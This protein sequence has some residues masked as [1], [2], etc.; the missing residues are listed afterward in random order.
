[1][2]TTLNI[3]DDVLSAA[4][5]IAAQERKT[6]GKVISELARQT[7]QSSISFERTR[8]GVVLLPA[9]S[10]A[11][12]VA[13]EDVNNVRDELDEREV[14]LANAYTA[15]SARNLELVDEFAAADKEGF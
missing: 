4:K 15:N 3:E 1:M 11:K 5:E 12:P 2:R 9:R 8:R 10:D 6:V 7:L 14:E 13:L